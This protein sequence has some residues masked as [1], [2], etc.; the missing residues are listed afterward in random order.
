MTQSCKLPEG[1]PSGESHVC[2]GP[3]VGKGLMY[4]QNRTSLE[5]SNG[6]EMESKDGEKQT[7]I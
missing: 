4:S 6:K 3:V 2:K 5:L 1:V 7:G